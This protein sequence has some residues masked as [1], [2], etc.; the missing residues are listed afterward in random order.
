MFSA[1]Y[2]P[3]SPSLENAGFAISAATVLLIGWLPRRGSA[4]V[5]GEYDVPKIYSRTAA[6][7]VAVVLSLLYTYFV[8]P[9]N[10][11]LLV[12]LSLIFLVF[13]LLGLVWTTYIGNRYGFT[14]KKRG[15]FGKTSR[16]VVLGASGSDL[17]DESKNIIAAKRKEIPR[18]EIPI[19]MLVEWA[20]ID[21]NPQNM[22]LVFTKESIAKIKIRARVAFLMFQTFGSL[23]LGTVGLLLS[24]VPIHP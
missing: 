20:Q 24:S 15:W 19:H 2:G 10:A 17:T 4:A 23:S 8:T 16:I 11:W 21:D 3:F 6:V 18:Q 12:I 13:M 1:G 7:I 9:E 14:F 5:P 22:E